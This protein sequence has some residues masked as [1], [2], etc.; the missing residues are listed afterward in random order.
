MKVYW[1]LILLAAWVSVAA[2]Q[3]GTGEFFETRIRPLLSAKCY[4]CHSAAKLGGLRVDSRAALLA[5]GKSGPAISPGQP[6]ASLLIRRVNSADAKLRMPLGAA[7][8]AD[9]EIA[10]LA[11]W[12]KAGAP[13]PEDAA[14]N[15]PAPST[16][17]HITAEQRAYW[18]FQP[19]AKAA[20]P[21]VKDAAWPRN[22]IDR[23]ILAK[24]EE[25]NLRPG[26]PAGKRTLIRRAT[27]DLTGLPP[28][29][30]EV[31]AFVADG[32]PD[33]FRKV[34]DR[35]LASP[36][37]GERWGRHWLDV[38]R[39]A[40]GD[41]RDL[42]PVYTGYG[43]AKDGYVN[44]FRY[45]DWVIDSFNRDLP[46]DTFVKAQIA[47]DLMP[48]KER[49]A[50]LAGLGFF[51]LGPWFTGDDVVF[52]E[53]RANERDDKI[54]ALTKGFLGL[55]VT[56]ARCH[57]HKYDPISQ[58]DYYALGGVFASSGYHEHNLAPDA[59][60]L[61]YKT[62]LA[63]V[64]AQETA[65]DEAVNQLRLEVA[66]RLAGQIPQ[67]FMA[68]RKLQLTRPPLDP[69]QVV[70][71]A[72]LDPETFVRWA[73]YLAEPKKIEYPFLK[74]WFA[75]IAQGGGT[76]EEAL[77]LAEE[78]RKLVL[79]VIAERTAL[80]GANEQRRRH[81]QP[82]P[83][84]ARVRLPGDL[85]QF[86]M[87]QFR[88]QIVE[89]PM[90]PHR[91][92]VWLD[93]VQSE[94]GDSVRKPGIFEFEYKDLVRFLKPAQVGN[95]K[96]MVAQYRALQK[97]LPPEYPYLM[98]IADNP[99]PSNLRVNLRG[100]PHALGDQTPRGLPAILANRPDD[101]P[102]PFT[103]GSGR[104]ELAEAIGHH[105]LAARVIANRVWMHHFAR[106][107]VATPSNFGAMGEP[108]THPELLDYLAARLIESG[109][110]I[111]ALHREIMLSATYQLSSEN[112][113]SNDAADPENRL[114][115]RGVM[116]RLDA[117]EIR[118]SL[119]F[120]AGSLD[121]T[122]GGP[123]LELSSPSNHRRTVYARIRRAD[124][125][126]TSGTGGV[127]RMLEL[128]DFADP[129]SSVDQRIDTNVPL[130]GLFFLN[131][132][133][134]MR[135]AELV[136]KRIVEGGGD[137]AARIQR[138]YRLLFARPAKDAEVQLGIDFLK[139]AGP[140]GWQQY[141]QVLLSSGSFYY[142]N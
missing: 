112:V 5:G 98:T 28:T 65:V 115:W 52:V 80:L 45:R 14:P 103:H 92:Y 97:E 61:R 130:Q 24:L 70:E 87:F 129:A 38:A 89:Q 134:V 33:A 91:Y 25:K 59:E 63:Q 108:P 142:V 6:E 95:L 22:A 71:E 53:A 8:L 131:S 29:P 141:A 114:L 35:L 44:T 49:P 12:V 40:D 72:N 27:Y 17:F 26:K 2:A 60:V 46:Y 117:E 20:P 104:L 54:D 79:D 110:S 50:L 55:T 7:K 102:A 62:Q 138:A 13:W 58:K 3:G 100:N 78:F 83:H 18:A 48:E 16:S 111:K 118:D 116:R 119:L 90:N 30:Q 34:V 4:A 76:D 9:G 120:V 69:R 66:R 41:G 101:N 135:Q 96:D 43:M 15:P 126:C 1:K 139:G 123:P 19:L 84:E 122:V 74:P 36:H 21:A 132:D 67:Y 11:A 136:A 105:P 75:L 107:I 99:E 88:Q 68:V 56:C 128:F 109:W 32:S 47:A 57:D 51:G 10:D 93:V 23:F 127:D 94:E 121:E 77:R 37:Y 31:D 124:Y 81:Y 85:M 39:Y 64:K 86:E 42:R 133:L 82:D 137:D 125:T 106:G 113:E 140:S 73:R